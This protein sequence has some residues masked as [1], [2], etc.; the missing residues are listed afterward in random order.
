M[1]FRTVAREAESCIQLWASI[2]PST[3]SPATNI[4]NPR[5]DTVYQHILAWSEALR[6]VGI[7]LS[8]WFI[9]RRVGMNALLMLNACMRE[10]GWRLNRKQN[11]TT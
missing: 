4:R 6:S 5:S 11:C 3:K 2:C 8:N 9:H 10:A 1:I 7:E